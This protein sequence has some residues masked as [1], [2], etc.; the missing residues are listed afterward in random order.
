[1]N[2]NDLSKALEANSPYKKLQ[3]NQPIVNKRFFTEPN[4]MA[5]PTSTETATEP[6]Q[7]S[8]ANDKADT[9]S[10]TKRNKRIAFYADDATYDLIQALAM[11]SN[12]TDIINQL[13]SYAIN[14]IP[15][16]TKDTALKQYYEIKES[17]KANLF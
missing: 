8:K 5:Q 1:M 11:T 7:E 2:K 17:I 13:L 6:T 9:K 4:Q 12:P 10:K 16:E 15:T 3:I 14:N